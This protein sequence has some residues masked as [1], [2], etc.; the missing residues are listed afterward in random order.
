MNNIFKKSAA[1]ILML[2]ILIPSLPVSAASLSEEPYSG[3]SYNVWGR[4]VPAPSGYKP[5]AVY[6]L[7]DLGTTPLKEAKDLF[8]Y[9]NKLYI[10]DTG[11]S[12]IVVL[13]DQYKFVREY[14]KF[15]NTLDKNKEL[16]L[17]NPCG[18]FIKDDTM[19]IADTGNG[20]VLVS[21][22]NGN[23]NNIIGKPTGDVIPA[24]F[25][26]EPLKV[27]QDNSGYVYVVANNV[28]KGLI[29]FEPNGNFA[30][31]YGSNKVQVDFFTLTKIFWSNLLRLI[32]PDLVTS[33]PKI[34]P[35]EITNMCI[36]SKNFIYTV[37]KGNSSPY[38]QPVGKLQM[39]NPSGI[40][41]LRYNQRDADASGGAIYSKNRYGDVEYDQY[42]GILVDSVV[43]DVQTDEDGIISILDRERGR[44]FQYDK[45]SNFLFVF[46][47]KGSQKGTF[48]IP[49][50]LEK[51][52]ED[53]IVLD[54]S[55]N[56]L[57]VFEPT[58]Y[59][60]TVKK[61]MS[62]YSEGLYK[63]AVEPWQQVLE[64]DSNNILAYRSIG[65]A[66]LQENKFDEALF[67]LKLGQDRDAYTIA[68]REYRKEFLQK[69]FTY[70]MIIS[71]V[72]I[73]ILNYLL[74]LL[75]KKLGIE[76]VKTKITF[77]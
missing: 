39:I 37:T 64:I 9:N 41:I 6:Y 28:N 22:L 55:K 15:I 50:A 8:V 58:Q 48:A 13:D 14:I 52:G 36:D 21:D 60:K 77:N 45:E 7:E 65:K 49:S 24:G 25:S 38:I 57:T 5:K 59:V 53:Y 34:V 66:K 32:S 35:T 11:N 51:M 61:A 63:D 30:G 23:V 69:Y 47:E 72:I 4:S 2:I 40:N 67:Y 26:Y 43:I 27:I 31:Y 46:G 56:N 70:I 3:Y 44:V 16:T 68:F 19:F 54:E 42:R 76:K 62:L 73:F 71:V 74:K 18:L 20:R 17:K 12:R 1:F 29:T 75:Q 33:L 10:V